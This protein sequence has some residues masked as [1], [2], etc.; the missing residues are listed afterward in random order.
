[1]SC[2]PAR[3]LSLP[4]GTLARARRPTSPSS[5]PEL[6]WTVDPERF[7]SR[8]RNTPFA[9]WKLARPRRPHPGG[10]AHRLGACKAE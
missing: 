5:I 7:V 9:G 1:M 8:S 6:E 4:G 10:R 2:A 3:A